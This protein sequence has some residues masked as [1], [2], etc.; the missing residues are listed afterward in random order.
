MA[1]PKKPAPAGPSPVRPE[2]STKAVEKATDIVAKLGSPMPPP[3]PPPQAGPQMFTIVNIWKDDDT[4]ADRSPATDAEKAEARKRLGLLKE[5]R[6]FRAESLAWFK[7]K[8]DRWKSFEDDQ[9]KEVYHRWEDFI[10]VV[11]D[12]GSRSGGFQQIAWIKIVHLLRTVPELASVDIRESAVRP[13]KD[14]DNEAIIDIV[15]VVK[16]DP[17]AVAVKAAVVVYKEWKRSQSTQTFANYFRQFAET[18]AAE[19]KVEADRKKLK[20]D[21]DKLAKA[22]LASELTVVE[23]SK[24]LVDGETLSKADLCKWALDVLAIPADGEVGPEW[25]E[26]LQALHRLKPGRQ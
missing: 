3:T 8:P 24:R 19:A 4:D 23:W 22:K 7:A 17:T 9:G 21:N 26:V 14:M 11:F 25:D 20:E 13:M 2:D 10:R 16:A 18:V 6:H 1:D 12:I 15:R 5:S